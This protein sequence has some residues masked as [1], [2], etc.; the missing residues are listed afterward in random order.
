MTG[1]NKK[2]KFRGE[3]VQFRVQVARE[4]ACRDAVH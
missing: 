2:C 3:M 4:L 1:T